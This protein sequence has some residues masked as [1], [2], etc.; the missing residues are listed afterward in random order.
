MPG[1]FF[2]RLIRPPLVLLSLCS[3]LGGGKT[4]QASPLPRETS[5]PASTRGLADAGGATAEPEAIA[6]LREIVARQKAV[7]A[8][9]RAKQDATEAEDL[10]PRLQRVVDDYERL[11][12]R[13]PRFAAGWAAYGLFLCDPA[14]EDHSAALALLLRAN[15][16]DPDIP[17]VKNQIGVIMAEQGRVIDAFN[18]FLAAADL[19]PTEPLYHFQI[20]LLLSEGREA[21][22]KSRAWKR[23]DLDRSMLEAFARAT[24]LAPERTDFAYRAAE[25]YYDLEEPR[26]E[27]AYRVWS[28]LEDRLS[29]QLESQTVRLHRARVLWKQGLAGDARDLAATVTASA[30]ATQKGRL[31]AEFDAEDE[32]ER[33]AAAERRATVHLPTPSPSPAEPSPALP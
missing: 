5:S 3:L 24:V 32:A 1:M 29:G 31:I 21:F 20:G 11:L 16:L 25:A 26:W 23:A 10:R 30:L 4:G 13:H 22:L 8:E 2:S 19:A 12:T 6:A 14:V 33:R 27:E 7:L 9:A 15:R 18:Y 28:A 17:V